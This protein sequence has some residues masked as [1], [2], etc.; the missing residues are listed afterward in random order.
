MLFRPSGHDFLPR[1]ARDLEGQTSSNP[2][3][4]SIDR[5]VNSLE[6]FRL[7]ISKSGLGA[8]VASKALIGW[9]RRGATVGTSLCVS[10]I[11]S[12]GVL[13]QA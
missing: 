6:N 1:P 7:Q 11:V 12:S 13:I 5:W 3:S 4:E 10:Q 8:G 2:D 9:L